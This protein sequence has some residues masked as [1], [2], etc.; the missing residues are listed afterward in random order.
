MAVCCLKKGS[1]S[2]GTTP[3]SNRLETRTDEIFHSGL[4]SLIVDQGSGDEVHD[5]CQGDDWGESL[6]KGQEIE[7]V[8][9]LTLAI[10][11]FCPA[12]GCDLERGVEA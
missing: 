4:M 6:S 12:R 7:A 3:G 5:Q 8:P 11:I 10:L 1:H 9:K 2:K